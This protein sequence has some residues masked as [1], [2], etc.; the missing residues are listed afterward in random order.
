M[1]DGCQQEIRMPGKPGR[2]EVRIP[3]HAGRLYAEI[4]ALPGIVVY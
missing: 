3:I 2:L 4:I 1:A